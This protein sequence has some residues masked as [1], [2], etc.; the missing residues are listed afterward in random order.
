MSVELVASVAIVAGTAITLFVILY[1]KKFRKK[2]EIVRS[3]PPKKQSPVEKW[4]TRT[5]KSITKESVT[6]AEDELRTLTLERE[7]LSHTIRRLY[8]AHAEGEITEEERETLAERYK[9]RMMKVKDAISE[10]ESVV[11]LHEL[12]AMQEDLTKLFNERFDELGSKIEELRTKVG[13]EMEE[14]IV[15]TPIHMPPQMEEELPQQKGRTQRSKKRTTRKPQKSRKTTAEER[16][17]KIRSDVEKVL[18]RLEQ[19]EAET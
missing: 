5:R 10:D 9:S 4:R 19:M 12:E 17:E 1:I 15:P 14:A 16:I 13:V 18:D 7:I 6:K 3:Q 11:A 2:G 8:E